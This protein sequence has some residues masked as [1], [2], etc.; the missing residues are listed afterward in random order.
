MHVLQHLIHS[1]PQQPGF[2]G[3]EGMCPSVSNFYER[4]L[5]NSVCVTVQSQTIENKQIK[6]DLGY[7][8][9]T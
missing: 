2:I 1:L 7:L 4:L 6:S 9:M 3:A 5:K 8:G